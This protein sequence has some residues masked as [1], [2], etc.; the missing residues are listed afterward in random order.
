MASSF[1]RKSIIVI[2]INIII[3]TT[4]ANHKATKYFTYG[5]HTAQEKFTQIHTKI[6]TQLQ[7]KKMEEKMKKSSSHSS[8]EFSVDSW[9]L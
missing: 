2:V 8:H 4:V 5:E 9:L 3:I 7:L 6:K 1:V